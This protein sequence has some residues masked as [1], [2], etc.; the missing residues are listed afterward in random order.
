[1]TSFLIKDYTLQPFFNNNK[2]VT[3]FK[4]NKNDFVKIKINN[5][6]II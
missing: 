5:N 3:S 4:I 1:M 6:D 2:K